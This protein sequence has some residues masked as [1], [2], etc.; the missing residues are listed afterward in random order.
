MG[1]IPTVVHT[2]EAYR[3]VYPPLYTGEAYREVYPG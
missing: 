3:E 2:G 1:G